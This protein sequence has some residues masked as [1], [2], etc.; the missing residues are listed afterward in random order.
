M[1]K[2]PLSSNFFKPHHTLKKTQTTAI[3]KTEPSAPEMTPAINPTLAPTTPTPAPVATGPTYPMPFSP[4]FN[5][6]YP[7]GMS[8]M[9]PFFLPHGLA[10]FSS[11]ANWM[12]PA[13]D[14]IPTTSLTVQKCKDI[15]RS[16]SPPIPDDSDVHEF[17]SM[18]KLGMETKTLLEQLNL[19]IRN[20]NNL[21]GLPK[22]VYESMGFTY[23]GWQWVLKAYAKYKHHLKAV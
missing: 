8:M 1:E 18:Y 13:H 20:N 22:D 12:L 10:T 5:P 3:D 16:S 11:Q 23:L 6:Y 14:Q 17:C 21:D 4:R 15:Q 19:Q 9:P 2:P 7:Y